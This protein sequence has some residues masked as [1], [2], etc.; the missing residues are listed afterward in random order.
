MSSNKTTRNSPRR[1]LEIVEAVCKNP[2]SATATALSQKLDIPA[3]TIY[4]WLDTLCEERFLA[5]H[6]SGHYVPG[7]RFRDMV[8]DSMQYEPKSQKEGQFCGLYLSHWERRSV[9][10]SPMEQSSFTLTDWNPTGL[11]RLIL[12]WVLHCHCIAVLQ[13]N[14]ICLR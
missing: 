11:S 10:R 3:P 12:K 6:T 4:R 7:E 13:G 8:L 14:S 9:F 5:A 1:I 2:E